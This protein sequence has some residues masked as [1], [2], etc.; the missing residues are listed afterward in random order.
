MSA[1][2]FHAAFVSPHSRA[3]GRSARRTDRRATGART[4]LLVLAVVLSLTVSANLL[5]AIGIPYAEPG[6]DPLL[7]FHPATA[8][9]AA[10]VLL[11][12]RHDRPA[13][14]PEA[15]PL[16]A[17]AAL[18]LAAAAWSVASVGPSGAAVYV[19]SFL[20]P[21]G[22]AFAMR[23][24]PAPNRRAIG[25]AALAAVLGN[26]VLA[27]IETACRTHLVPIRLEDRI[28]RD[29]P[30]EFRSAALFDH[31]LT[32]SMA[33]MTALLVLP[34]FRLG[35]G[36]T[37]LA[38]ILLMLGLLAFGGRAAIAAALLGG[39]GALAL[40]FVRR[41]LDRRLSAASLATIVLAG[42]AAA[43]ALAALLAATSLGARIGAH[44]YVD[45]S[46][47][48][49]TTEWLLPG[50]LDLRS[51]LFGTPIAVTPTLV[52]RLGLQYPFTDI[53]NFWLMA[54]LDLGL[55]G[56]ALYAAAIACLVRALWRA[57]AHPM[58]RVAIAALLL[59]ASTS[60]SL[61]RKSNVLLVLV[62]L[63]CAAD[64]S[65]ASRPPP[66]RAA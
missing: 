45:A 35:R 26:V 49:R 31:P 51:L 53:E 14:P 11:A 59:V 66:R 42:A 38:S 25:L 40:A 9:I 22:L 20:A 21:G 48:S 5:S 50:M 46:A 47:Q 61:G 17:F 65:P 27:L 18:M 4:A 15:R 39:G 58:A 32:A 63:V 30:G 36:R 56:F 52:W 19:E 55:L 34:A 10:A 2:A 28:L 13:L 43:A 37:A 12:L 54:F 60:N 41:A 23:S 6:G 44:L 33:A 64:A 24:L 62:A 29:A 8:C 16:A 7:K 57:A 1:H 3:T